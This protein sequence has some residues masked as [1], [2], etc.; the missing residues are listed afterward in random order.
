MSTN[1]NG[2][3]YSDASYGSKKQM[4]LY[5]TGALNGTAAA[6]ATVGRV[7][8][9][10]PCCV[11][12]IGGVAT[13]GGTDAAVIS[14]L[15][16]KSVAGT[17]AVSVIGTMALSTHAID[18]AINGSVTATAFDAGD[19]LVIQRSLGTST[20]VLDV[21]PYVLYVEGYQTSNN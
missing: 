12:D 3:S 21:L 16:G 10:V 5:N 15:V 11:E 2:R 13:V 6:A 17:G 4:S 14:V 7:R 18:T 8:F 9:M 1:T 19:D 20:S